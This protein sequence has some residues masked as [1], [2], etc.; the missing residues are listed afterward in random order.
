MMLLVHG[1][2]LILQ[3]EMYL[4]EFVALRNGGGVTDKMLKI[5]THPKCRCLLGLAQSLQRFLF[6]QTHTNYYNNNNTNINPLMAYQML[7]E[8][9]LNQYWVF[10]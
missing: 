6:T 8:S 2:P 9:V 1:D 10:Y 5:Y 4:Y 3:T 7:L